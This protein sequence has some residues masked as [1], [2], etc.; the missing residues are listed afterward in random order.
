MVQ[1]NLKGCVAGSILIHTDRADRGEG[2][3]E[4]IWIPSVPRVSS[5]AMG[6][7]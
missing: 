2:V 1:W 6:F 5:A 4:G 3:N 7:E